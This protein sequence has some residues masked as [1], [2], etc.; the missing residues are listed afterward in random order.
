MKAAQ[1]Q[2]SCIYLS[3]GSIPD[4]KSNDTKSV[5]AKAVLP[6]CFHSTLKTR[7]EPRPQARPEIYM[8]PNICHRARPVN[9]ILEL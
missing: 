5:G 2:S 8:I 9:Q 3:T 1:L 6:G 4:T 7:N